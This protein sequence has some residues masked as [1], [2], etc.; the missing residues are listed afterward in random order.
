MSDSRGELPHI[1]VATV[2]EREGRFLM[3]KE[4]S[5]DGIVFNQ[6]AGHVEKQET[7]FAAALRETLEET[8]WHVELTGL[9]GVYHYTSAAN[10]VTYIRHCF[11]AKALHQ[12]SNAELD[13]D[14]IEAMWLTEEEILQ[15]Q[16][17]L[18]S[19]IVI[20]AIEHYRQ[21]LSFPLSLINET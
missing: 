21:G 8:G 4:T 2:V 15:R 11:I 6:P 19:P 7:L 12:D 17:Q 3:V 20:Q 13:P 18:R 1:T 9:L 16:E 10:N 5:G 14:I